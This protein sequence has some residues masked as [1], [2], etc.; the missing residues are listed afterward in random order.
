LQTKIEY[1]AKERGIAVVKIDPSYTSQRC[2]RCGYIDSGNRKSQSKF[3]CK[4]CGFACNADYNASQNISIRDIAE[5]IKKE[6][7]AK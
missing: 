5:I 2:S 7:S 1:K 4:S 3:C 6:R